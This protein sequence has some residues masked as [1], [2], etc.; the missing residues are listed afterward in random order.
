MTEGNDM[1]YRNRRTITTTTTALIFLLLVAVASA[2]VGV[3]PD[4]FKAGTD[5]EGYEIGTVETDRGRVAYIRSLDADPE[6]FGNLMQTF[7]AA[8]Y[9]GQRIRL[10]AMVRTMEVANW[11]G[12]WMR[13][14]ANKQAVA[15]DNMQDRALKGSCDWRECS[16]VL[17][18]SEDA[19]SIS[20]G[21]I[22][23]GDGRAEWDA[24]AV[25]TVS[26]DVSLTGRHHHRTKTAP[27]NLNFEN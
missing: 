15:F 24:I 8:S 27:T 2:E 23:V 25:E 9:R 12:M 16:I 20:M 6:K 22:L 18:V 7:D 21:L 5:P 14:D 26:R 1:Q 17:D 10:S 3:V 11:A 13:V 4:W 19:D